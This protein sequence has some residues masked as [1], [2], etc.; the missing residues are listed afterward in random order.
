VDEV[1]G[2]ELTSGGGDQEPRARTT[3]IVQRL[4]DRGEGGIGGTSGG[5][6]VEAD[7]R[8]LARDVE[9]ELASG[10]ERAEG[11]LVAHGE[12]GGRP[13]CRPE[14]R[15]RGAVALVASVDRDF[16]DVQCRVPR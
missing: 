4:A 9:A 14:K 12:H 6:V 2:G 8:H 10:S 1:G 11:E 15:E 3:L 16:V 13:R 5:R 7:D